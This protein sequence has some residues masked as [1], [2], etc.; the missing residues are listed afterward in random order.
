MYAPGQGMGTVPQAVR[1][2]CRD[3]AA[4]GPQFTNHDPLH[5][6]LILCDH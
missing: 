5:A 2:E 4:L 6:P 3:I 1:V